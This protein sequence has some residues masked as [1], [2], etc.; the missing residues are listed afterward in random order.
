MAPVGRYLSNA[1]EPVFVG[2]L[3]EK[4]I[5]A[6][7][8]EGLAEAGG[9]ISGEIAGAEIFGGAIE[10]VSGTREIQIVSLWWIWEGN[11]LLSTAD[12]P[13]GPQ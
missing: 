2:G 6:K 10:A 4:R 12:A 13:K 11:R 1:H 7:P 5:G 8:G 9:R 3:G